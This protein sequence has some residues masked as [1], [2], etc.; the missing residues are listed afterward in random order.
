MSEPAV[1]VGENLGFIE[2]GDGEGNQLPVRKET[3]ILESLVEPDHDISKRRVQIG[4][5]DQF[6][7][8]DID[9]A[10]KLG[11]RSEQL[12]S[13]VLNTQYIGFPGEERHEPVLIK[14]IVGFI[15]GRVFLEELIAVSMDGS[16]IATAETIDETAAQPC[17]HP[18]LDAHFE[19]F[20]G[21]LRKRE[22]HDCFRIHTFH[23]QMRNPLRHDFRLS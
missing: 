1:H 18:L 5:R 13:E 12:S 16:D 23:E 21:L 19:I 10:Y 8:D 3:I 20:R 7:V 15:P 2:F 14:D 4:N 11:D 22:R 17:L 6:I 9:V